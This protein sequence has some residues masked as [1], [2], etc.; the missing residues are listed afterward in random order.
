MNLKYLCGTIDEYGHDDGIA[1]TPNVFIAPPVAYMIAIGIT[2]ITG[3]VIASQ[4][5]EEEP[6]Q[7]PPPPGGGIYFFP[8][9]G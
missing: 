1:I 5:P 2:V 4:F 9:G 3:V 6:P 7:P 8:H